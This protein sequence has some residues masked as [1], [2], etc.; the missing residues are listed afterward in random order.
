MALMGRTPPETWS[1]TPFQQASLM[2]DDIEAT[3]EELRDKGVTI[4][5]EISNQG[6]GLCTSIDVP[7]AGWLMLYQP[8]HPLAYELDG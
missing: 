2:C 4:R 6:Y 3:V 1:S 8:R 7:G 5:D